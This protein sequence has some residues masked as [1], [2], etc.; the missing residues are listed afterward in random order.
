MPTQG[1]YVDEKLTTTELLLLILF[2]V[3]ILL[4]MLID[5]PPAPQVVHRENVTAEVRFENNQM[6]VEYDGIFGVFPAT[7]TDRLL[8]HTGTIRVCL[9]DLETGEHVLWRYC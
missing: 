6:E 3:C 7:E 5:G 2:G 9:V 8:G 4:A 1:G